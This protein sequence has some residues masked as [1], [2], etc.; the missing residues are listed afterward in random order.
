MICWGNDFLQKL[1]RNCGRPAQTQ[2]DV[3]VPPLVDSNGYMEGFLQ[4]KLL[5][6]DHFGEQRTNK[7]GEEHWHFYRPPELLSKIFGNNMQ[8][9][10]ALFLSVFKL[11][12][13]SLCV[14][15]GNAEAER[16]FSCQNRIKIKSRTLLSI[17]QLDKLIRLSYLGV[18]IEDVDYEAVRIIFDQRHPRI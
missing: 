5:V 9:N 1:L 12:S 16:V 8:G 7:N 18:P 14:P 6:I 10:Q 11:M 17:S 3:E 4:F 15:V 2:G 13:L